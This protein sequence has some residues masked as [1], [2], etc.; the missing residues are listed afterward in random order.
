MPAEP[1]ER[2]YLLH[3]VRILDLTML[4][5]G[6]LCTLLLADWGAEVIKIEPR[7]AGDGMRLMPDRVRQ[8]SAYFLALNRNKKSLAV[9][10]RKPE[11]Q[12]I[13]HRLAATAD[14]LIEG[15]RPGKMARLGLGYPELRALNSR[16]V[17]CSLSGYGQ[18]GPWSGRAGHDLNYLALSG[19]LSLSGDADGPPL[20]PAMPLADIAGAFMAATA[21][22]AALWARERSGVG[23]YLDVSLYESSMYWLTPLVTALR[24]AGVR[25]QR[26][27]LGLTGAWPCYGVYRTR[28]GRY[29]SLAAIEPYFW[30][31]FC[32]R[33]GREDWVPLGRA[34][35]EEGRRV[36]QEVSTLF[37]GHTQ[38]EWVELLHD[39]DC[40]CEPV[41]ELSEALDHPQAR[42]RGVET[43]VTS[44][45][46][47]PLSQLE[48][49]IHSDPAPGAV[50]LPPPR[51]GEHTAPLLRELGYTTEEIHELAAARV[52]GLA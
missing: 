47:G 52:V 24:S 38:A 18:D 9:D 10:L 16:L 48:V 41:L 36:R 25:P 42:H 43:Q 26:G 6:P 17:Y 39:A 31:A 14:V 15:F 49:P 7:L 19:L 3:N 1:S 22:L 37:A 8:E 40:C 5:P 2:S 45:T 33:V 32:R 11:G 21:I 44:P 29:M 20:P 30:S 34:E 46:E 23:R 27:Q 28:D 12:R 50:R 35:G 51:L 13:A 4:L